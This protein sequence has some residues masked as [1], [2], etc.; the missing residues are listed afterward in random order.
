MVEELDE[1]KDAEQFKELGFAEGVLS[2]MF[3]RRFGN[4]W[5]WT[6][7]MFANNDMAALSEGMIG[8]KEAWQ[9]TQNR[10]LVGLLTSNPTLL[11]GNAPRDVL[12]TLQA[13]TEARRH[14]I[15]ATQNRA[16]ESSAN[17]REPHRSKRR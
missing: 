6:P 17:V 8:L 13:I 3:L 5:G 14:R 9:V 7:V 2:Y 12:Q 10:L 1:L 4:K 11:D 15:L 16:S